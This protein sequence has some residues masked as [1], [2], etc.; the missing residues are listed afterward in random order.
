MATPTWLEV[1]HHRKIF[2]VSTFG[3]VSAGPP[4]VRVRIESFDAFSKELYV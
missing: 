2:S 4:P 1:K 3:I